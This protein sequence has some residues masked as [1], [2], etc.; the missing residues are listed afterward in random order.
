LNSNLNDNSNLKKSF[1]DLN[2]DEL[3]TKMNNLENRF[4]NKTALTLLNVSNNITKDEKMSYA[5]QI[6]KKVLK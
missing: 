3:L 4:T 2:K 5:E 1:T 6:I